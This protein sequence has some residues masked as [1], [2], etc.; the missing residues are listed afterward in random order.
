MDAT[1]G[2]ETAEGRAFESTPVPQE[3]NEE[4]LSP[5]PAAAIEETADAETTPGGAAL[6]VAPAPEGS[7]SQVDIEE[8]PSLAPVTEVGEASGI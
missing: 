6:D 4:R 3:P 2:G 5:T 7:A 1:S 8:R